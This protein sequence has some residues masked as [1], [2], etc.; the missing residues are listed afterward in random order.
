MTATVMMAIMEVRDQ[1]KAAERI[2]TGMIIPTIM[3]MIRGIA[4]RRRAVPM[5][6]RGYLNLE[7]LVE[8]LSN[9]RWHSWEVQAER[10]ERSLLQ[11][12]ALGRFSL[13]E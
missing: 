9:N 4:D 12:M 3:D 6:T 10:I 11:A 1:V 5:H 13:R 2:V 8:Q 7:R